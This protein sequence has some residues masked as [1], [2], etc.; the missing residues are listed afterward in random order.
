VNEPVT[1]ADELSLLLGKPIDLQ[2]LQVE[3]RLAVRGHLIGQP[4]QSMRRLLRCVETFG[5]AAPEHLV[6]VRLEQMVKLL[7]PKATYRIVVAERDGPDVESRR[8]IEYLRRHRALQAP[9]VRQTADRG[10][11]YRICDRQLDHPR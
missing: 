8:H 3:D 4:A 6:H 5:G 10:G 11:R 7:D 9:T 1:E 2:S